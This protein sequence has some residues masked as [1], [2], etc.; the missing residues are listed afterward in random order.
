MAM[1][2]GLAKEKHDK[3]HINGVGTSIYLIAT[4]K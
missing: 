1:V 4:K 2:R 3:Y